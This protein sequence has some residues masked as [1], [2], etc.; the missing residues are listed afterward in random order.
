MIQPL[1]PRGYFAITV[2]NLTIDVSNFT[3]KPIMYV[4]EFFKSA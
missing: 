4:L 1:E 2:S 3:A